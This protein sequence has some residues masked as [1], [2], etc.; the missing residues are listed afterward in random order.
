MARKPAAH[1]TPLSPLLG[2]PGRH[3]F[4]SGAK[5]GFLN[6]KDANSTVFLLRHFITLTSEGQAVYLSL[7]IGIQGSREVR[8]T[9]DHTGSKPELT[10]GKG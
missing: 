5:G 2:E 4:H 10:L 7:S 6:G 1:L 3:H 9:Q 8:D